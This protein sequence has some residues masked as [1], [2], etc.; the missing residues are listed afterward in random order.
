MKT[1]AKPLGV[2]L[3]EASMLRENLLAVQLRPAVQREQQVAVAARVFRMD[4]QL[5][6]KAFDRFVNSAIV[7]ERV[8]EVQICIRQARVQSDR[9]AISGERFQIGRASC[10]E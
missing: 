3:V 7:P 5:A 4:A 2:N 10:R 8:A 1:L 9:A 6:A